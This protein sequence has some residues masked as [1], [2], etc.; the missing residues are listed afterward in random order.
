MPS[1]ISHLFTS[2]G[3]RFGLMIFAD[4][5]VSVDS[6]RELS[7]AF[8]Q[9]SYAATPSSS[10]LRVIFIL[11]KISISMQQLLRRDGA[12]TSACGAACQAAS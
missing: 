11:V 5:N 12:A 6:C 10:H 7:S 8:L 9:C 2:G 1:I 4:A 3:M